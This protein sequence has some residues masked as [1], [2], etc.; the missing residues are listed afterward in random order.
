[1]LCAGP[2]T[3]QGD[4]PLSVGDRAP[5][6]ALPG[7]TAHGVLPDSVR[8]SDFAG[9]TVVISFFFRAKAGP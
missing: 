5:K 8:L 9:R 7:A 3:A 1:V 4:R 6:F 2:L